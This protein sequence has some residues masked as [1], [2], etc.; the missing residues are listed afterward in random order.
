MPLWGGKPCVQVL[1]VNFP[2]IELN[3]LLPV[4]HQSPGLFLVIGFWSK[5]D[6]LLRRFACQEDI[7][8]VLYQ[9]TA[10]YADIIPLF[11]NFGQS[12]E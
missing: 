6:I 12:A 2:E 5:Y 10:N 7:K 4:W 9:H 3:G 8:L 11:P 1:R